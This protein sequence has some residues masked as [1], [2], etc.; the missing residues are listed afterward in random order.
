MEMLGEAMNF[1]GEGAILAAVVGGFAYGFL[2]IGLGQVFGAL[3][4][5]ALNTR[6]ALPAGSRVG[7]GS[8]VGLRF[9]SGILGL[10]GVLVILAAGIIV[11]VALTGGK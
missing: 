2:L 9:V 11:A 8:Y 4:E 7:S 1:G 3:R 6:A 10:L 5:I